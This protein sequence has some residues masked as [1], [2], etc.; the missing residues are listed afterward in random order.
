[1]RTL[2]LLVLFTAA[3]ITGC[4]KSKSVH[5]QPAM[6]RS[7]VAYDLYEEEDARMSGG[8]F[9]AD[10]APPPPPPPPSAPAAEPAPTT[11]VPAQRMVHYSA[12]MRLRHPRAP[13][14]V[15]AVE[16]LAVEAGG[17]VEQAGG[18]QV[19]VRVPVEAFDATLAQ[20]R[21]LAP[22][23]GRSVSASDVTDA[24]T[25]VELRLR[26]ARQTLARL[27]ELLAR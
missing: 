9:A 17:F 5:A 8:T 19:T 15:D 6:E 4:Q 10:D 21:E 25:A 7:S 20:I 26:T 1:M 27:Q 12:W 2:W 13:Q 14:I 22:V 24:F 23:V 11:P 18:W 3:A 16:Q